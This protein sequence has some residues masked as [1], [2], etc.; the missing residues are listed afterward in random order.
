MSHT[1]DVVEKAS[2]SI[3][4]PPTTSEEEGTLSQVDKKGPTYIE[5]ARL[6]LVLFGVVLVVFMIML[7]QTIMVA[8]IPRIS[9][10]FN[11]LKDIGWYGAVYLFTTYVV[12][13]LLSIRLLAN[14][15]I[16]QMFFAAI[17]RK[18]VSVL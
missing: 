10:Q 12:F 4:R 16:D 7:D 3:S 13:I 11:S 9:S 2:L 18:A 14:M 6:Y 1:N 17:D 15:S 5:G 8:A